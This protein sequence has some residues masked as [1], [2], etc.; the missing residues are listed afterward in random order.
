MRPSD[1]L[2]N[3][4]RKYSK[5]YGLIDEI[6]KDRGKDL[7]N[8]PKWCF[9]PM[10][11]FYAVISKATGYDR[12]PPE[13]ISDVGRLSAI[14]TW[15][16]SQGIY[17]FDPDIFDALW[18]TKLN[19]NLPGDV[20]LRLP[21]WSVYI[22]TP[23]K[24]FEGSKI[25]GFWA[26]LEHDANDNRRELRLLLDLEET[27]LPMPIHIGNWPL[28]T[29]LEKVMAES[30]KYIPSTFD[31]EIPQEK[32]I[33]AISEN[34][35][36]LI[37]LVLYLCSD[38]PDFGADKKPLRPKAKKTKKHGWRLF[39]APGPTIWHIGDRIG[40]LIRE[41]RESEK[42]DSSGRTIKSHIRRAHW[43]GY[44]SGPLT[45]KRRFDYQW[46][47]PIPVGIER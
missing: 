36:P 46:M 11:G 20:L 17:R 29:G 8:W 25:F 22:E 14:A 19:G 21:E 24:K 28:K 40:K 27:L 32:E 3:I 26:H 1:H 42:T 9:M 37:S 7:P 43:H 47:P 38:R 35:M 45:G 44:W 13:L 12:L 16:Y 23:E 2:N 15:R 4:N 41:A 33:S 10:A 31:T 6:R 5:G 18:T 34:Y 30:R 39:Q